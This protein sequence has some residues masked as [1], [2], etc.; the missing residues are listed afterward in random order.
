MVFASS[1][2]VTDSLRPKLTVIYDLSNPVIPTPDTCITLDYRNGGIIDA[3]FRDDYP[4]NNYGL[5]PNFIA[6]AWTSGGTS[7]IERSVLKFDLS[8]IPY[9]ATIN[10][11]TLSLF[12]NLT[13]G[14]SQLHSSLSGSN[15]CWLRRVTSSWQE[16]TVTWNNQPSFTTQ[17]QVEIQQSAT[18]TQD[19]PAI[20]VTN[21]VKDMIN[22]PSTSY[23]FMISLQTEQL[24]RSMVFASKDNADPDLRPVLNI[25]YSVYE[26][27]NKYNKNDYMFNVYPNPACDFVNIEPINNNEY[28]Y[29]IYNIQGNILKNATFNGDIKIDISDFSKGVYFI[30]V[31]ND[32]TNCIK[33]IIKN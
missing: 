11:A 19:Y 24:Y 4:N 6:N 17:N 18:Q 15:S 16:N 32:K 2:H 22:Y 8:T 1:D 20:D 31:W 27:I 28:Y 25:C 30:N 5:F 10:S 9:N 7:F 12:C 3:E 33:K 26:N 21:L 29:K 23:G 13:S 14:H